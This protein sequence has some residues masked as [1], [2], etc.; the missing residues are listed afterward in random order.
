MSSLLPFN[1]VLTKEVKLVKYIIISILLTV[2]VAASVWAQEL[3]LEVYP[4]FFK[5]AKI[6]PDDESSMFCGIRF[7]IVNPNPQRIEHIN[8]DKFALYSENRRLIT[9]RDL[10]ADAWKHLNYVSIEPFK[11]FPYLDVICI[12][13]IVAL[14]RYNTGEEQLY[15]LFEISYSDAYDNVHSKNFGWTYSQDKFKTYSPP[16]YEEDME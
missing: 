5:E 8:I 15:I 14:D 4:E 13:P 6:D 16:Q 11:E 10:G 3:D 1:A 2:C 9:K 7:T 12:F